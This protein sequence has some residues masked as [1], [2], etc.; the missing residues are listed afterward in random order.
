MERCWRCSPRPA[1]GSGA[2]RPRGAMG[3]D[4]RRPWVY[5]TTNSNSRNGDGRGMVQAARGACRGGAIRL[6][7]AGVV[8]PRCV[9]RL[10][11]CGCCRVRGVRRRVS[12]HEIAL[13]F[14][15]SNT[16]M[17][18]RRQMSALHHGV[19]EAIERQGR[20]RRLRSS[21]LVVGGGSSA[22]VRRPDLVWR[23]AP[24]ARAPWHGGRCTRRCCRAAGD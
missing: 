16:K 3:G 11:S 9:P 14:G 7:D 6:L 5:T 20:V 8:R 15:L 19:R 22:S 21:R 17:T 23:P 24:A 18:S 4:G 2:V 10:R 12:S 13:L 1:A